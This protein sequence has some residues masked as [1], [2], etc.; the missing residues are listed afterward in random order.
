[1]IQVKDLIIVRGGGDLATGT[2]H[3]LWSAGLPVLVLETER[4][5]A[6]RRQ[7]SISEAIY[8]GKTTVE[9]MEGVRVQDDREALKAIAAGKIPVRADPRGESIGRLRP[10]VVVDAVL[11]KKNIGTYKEMAALTIALGPGYE[12]GRDVDLVIE[13]MRGHDLGRIIRK[14]TALA[15]TGIP[16][17]IGGYTA[18]RVI[19]ATAAGRLHNIRRIGDVVRAGDEIAQ[20]VR[21]DGSISSVTAAI[22]G[23]LRGLLREGYPVTEGFK[24]ADVDPRQDE[25]DNCFTISDKAR[26]IAGSVLEAVIAFWGI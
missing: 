16:G 23:I 4:P 22:P 7:V 9:G 17:N 6:I 20:I 15:D 2:V 21:K 1:M 11:A 26:C 5:A 3:R 12:A 19:H 10:A 13:T 14:G 18:E 8:D 24:I 25:L